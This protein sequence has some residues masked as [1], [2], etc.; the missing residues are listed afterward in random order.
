MNEALKRI[1]QKQRYKLV[2]GHSG[3]KLCHWMRQKLF[4]GRVCYKETFYG[5]QCHRCLQ[6]TPT[7]NQCNQ[8]CLFC[9][10]YQGFSE[11]PVLQEWDE[12]EAI[13]DGL[14]EAQRTRLTGFKGDER[15]DQMLWKEA[16]EPN[17]AAI[18][19]SG[20]PTL[21][22][23]L[24]GLLE[25]CKSR[26][27]TTFL[28]SNGT[29]PDALEELDTLP[30]QLYITVAAPNE[31]VYKQL[32]APGIRDGWQRLSKTLELLPSL[33]TRTV[34]RH[35]L[36]DQWNICRESEYAKLVSL[37]EPDF[38]EAK[39]YVFVGDSRRRMTIANMPSHETI[40]GFAMKLAEQTG[41]DLI[42]EKKAS[43]VVLLGKGTDP[44]LH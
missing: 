33:N 39:A 43:R 15:T 17:M 42:M 18:S 11:E 9:W 13:L 3:A 21:Y 12:L 24:G 10:R 4:Y 5:I 30:T 44:E 34:V 23:Y 20:E 2:G 32:C 28:V 26:A 29:N 25:L 35:T 22:P 19:L 31:G 37:A 16:Q 41:Y 38:I 36:V 7:I 1:L 6:M 8:N 27:M 40:K 14:M